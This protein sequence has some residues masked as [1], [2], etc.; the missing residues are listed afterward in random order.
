M[1]PESSILPV[2][3]RY[4]LNCVS[5]KFINW[6]FNPGPQ[7]VTTEEDWPVGF[8]METDVMEKLLHGTL[9]R[10]DPHEA[11]KGGTYQAKVCGVFFFCTCALHHKCQKINGNFYLELIWD[12][13]GNLHLLSEYSAFLL[14]QSLFL[15]TLT[16]KDKSD[17]AMTFVREKKQTTRS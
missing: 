13:L 14:N 8:F 17:L 7:N 6:S 1:N 2:D 3:K 10:T 9:I 5:L 4:R 12:S 11:A 16:S 15:E